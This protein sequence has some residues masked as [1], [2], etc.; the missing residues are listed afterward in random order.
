[1]PENP[2]G[3]Q[4]STRVDAN[5]VARGHKA[6]CW[7]IRNGRVEQVWVVPRLTRSQRTRKR[8]R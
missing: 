3:L 4:G 5:F 2:V 7:G 6:V 8:K 1:M